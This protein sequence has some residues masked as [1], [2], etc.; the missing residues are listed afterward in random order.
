[1]LEKLAVLV[2]PPRLNLVRYHDVLAP[3]CPDRAQAVRIASLG[4]SCWPGYS[5]QRSRSGLL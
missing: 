4:P 1:M 3:A 5:V 2:P